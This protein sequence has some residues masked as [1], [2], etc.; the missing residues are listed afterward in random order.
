MKFSL[1]FVCFFLI[2]AIDI[3][4][5]NWLAK[6][7]KPGSECRAMSTFTIGGDA[8]LVG[9]YNGS[10]SLTNTWRYTVETDSWLEMA[11]I[12]NPIRFASGFAINGKGYV[13]CGINGSSNH[14]SDI[15]E[16]DPTLDVWNNIGDFP[17]GSRYGMYC[18]VIGDKAYMGCGNSGSSNGPFY[19]NGFA[20]DPADGTW[21]A[22]SDCPIGERYG[23]TGFSFNGKGYVIGGLD[24]SDGT[25]SLTK[26]VWSYDPTN[27]EWTQVADYPH[28]TAF[29]IV[30]PTT[31]G[32]IVGGGAYNTQEVYEYYPSVNFWYPISDYPGGAMYSSTSFVIEGQYF[33]GCGYNVG[34]SGY[35]NDLWELDDLQV[36]GLEEKDN[37]VVSFLF[38]NPTSERATLMLKGQ[39]EELNLTIFDVYGRQMSSRAYYNVSDRLELDFSEF[40]PGIY[41]INIISEALFTSLK[42]V[43]E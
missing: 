8:Y 27:D 26:E 16:Y 20:F 35:Y 30:L 31:Q 42:I 18:F 39:Q 40:E 32:I 17:G 36:V 25:S 29:Q 6:S 4:A 41:I 15:W 12:P 37:K 1:L 19:S 14:L 24:G 9:G 43:V 22:I 33:V 11:N 38:P 23:V 2:N 7:D 28:L 3:S 13:V 21:T 34:V 10:F 5:Q